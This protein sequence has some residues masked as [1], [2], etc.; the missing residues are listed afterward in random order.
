MFV[1]IKLTLNNFTQKAIKELVKSCEII[2]EV[3]KVVGN[4]G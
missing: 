4:L 2:N 1:T 3:D